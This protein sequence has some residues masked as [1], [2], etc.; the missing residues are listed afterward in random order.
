MPGMAAL[1]QRQQGHTTLQRRQNG[2][3]A[4]AI[5]TAIFYP[6]PSERY[7]MIFA[8]QE[9]AERLST[10]AVGWRQFCDYLVQ[11][12]YVLSPRLCSRNQAAI[13]IDA[14]TCFSA[15]LNIQEYADESWNISPVKL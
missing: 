13:V 3:S 10:A 15:V 5:V 11:Y 9:E 2:I 6:Q 12:G 4:E 14:V 1:T 8:P 7:C